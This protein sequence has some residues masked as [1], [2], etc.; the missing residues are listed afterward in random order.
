MVSNRPSP[1]STATMEAKI[2]PASPHGQNRVTL[3]EPDVPKS[4]FQW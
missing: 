4:A 2:E 3:W 1:F